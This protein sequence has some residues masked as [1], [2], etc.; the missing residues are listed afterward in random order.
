MKSLFGEYL[1]GLVKLGRGRITSPE[2]D[3]ID[4]DASAASVDDVEP[5]EEVRVELAM[6]DDAWK[7]ISSRP[8][9]PRFIGAQLSCKPVPA[10]SRS[11]PGSASH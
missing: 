10:L 1:N 5:Q 4:F 6:V 8:A 11:L 9:T 3:P 2:S 7:V